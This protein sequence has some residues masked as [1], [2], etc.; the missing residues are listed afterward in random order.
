MTADEFYKTAIVDDSNPV[1]TTVDVRIFGNRQGEAV[2]FYLRDLRGKIEDPTFTI[3][4]P[5]IVLHG[6][7]TVLP[8]TAVDWLKNLKA[9]RV[10]IGIQEADS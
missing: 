6:R 8:S 2:D 1:G 4:K 7:G 10:Q 5:I 9:L 3:S